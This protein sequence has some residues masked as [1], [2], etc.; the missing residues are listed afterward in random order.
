MNSNSCVLHPKL[1]LIGAA[2]T[3]TPWERENS[4]QKLPEIGDV[5]MFSMNKDS[6]SRGDLLSELELKVEVLQHWHAALDPTSEA[7]A[8]CCKPK[9]DCQGLLQ[10]RLVLSS[11]TQV[12]LHSHSERA[13]QHPARLFISLLTLPGK[14]LLA[15]YEGPTEDAWQHLDSSQNLFCC[16][17]LQRS[18]T[19][20]RSGIAAGRG[21]S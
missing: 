10:F 5:K 21:P 1:L 17:L 19:G 2:S 16:H 8:S 7:A 18:A 9:A 6:C 12:I 14:P 11:Q 15:G 20:Y 13:A 4:P 3:E